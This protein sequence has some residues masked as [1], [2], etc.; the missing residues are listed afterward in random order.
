[1]K[2]TEFR[3]FSTIVGQT[4]VN[5]VLSDIKTGRHKVPV[6]FLRDCLANGNKPEFDRRKRE[7]EGVTFAGMF[8]GGRKLENLIEYSGFNILDIDKLDPVTLRNVFVQASRVQFTYACFRSPSNLGIKILVRTDNLAS[9]HTQAF[10][11][12][13]SYYEQL[14]DITI[15]P[16]GKDITRLCFYSYDP[17]TY[18]NVNSQIFKTVIMKKNKEIEQ[19]VKQIETQKIDITSGYNAWLNVGFALVDALG[20]NAR[21]YYH[22]VSAFNPEYSAEVC[23]KQFD[24]C[25]KSKRQGITASTFFY[26]AK[27]HGIDISKIK[28]FDVSTDNCPKPENPNIGK[29]KTKK[30]Y[31]VFDEAAVFLKSKIVTRFNLVTGLIEYTDSEHPAFEPLTDYVENNLVIELNKNQIMI[32]KD[33]LRCLLYSDFSSRFDPFVSYFENLPEW[34]NETDYITLLADTV[35]ID[36]FL[37]WQNAF[38]KWI[39]AVVA[40]AIDRNA[41]NHTAIVFTGPQGVGKTTW[42]LKLCPPALN[43]YVFSGTINPNNKD[44]LIHISECILINLDELENLNRSEIGSLKEIITKST[45]RFRRAYGHYSEKLVRRA[46][47]MGSVNTSQFLTDVTGSRRFLC[48]E[49]N[50]IEFNHNIDIDLVYAQAYA[51]YKSGFQYYFTKEEAAEISRRNER[52]RLMPPEEELLLV[53][54]KPVDASEA[55]L[56]LSASQIHS[57]LACKTVL[58]GNNSSVINLGKALRKHGFTR[59]KKNGVYVWALYE[60]SSIEVDNRFGNDSYRSPY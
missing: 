37:V 21:E 3:N 59:L 20:E 22:R 15:D 26:L 42:M 49:T 23:N 18:V 41:V 24:N 17:D 34:D 48:F 60:Y 30:T 39:V 2:I 25:L 28:S 35:Q 55:N 29:P 12:I 40:C 5:Q 56:F 9:N 16:S 19:V 36:D 45:I 27:E 54:F 47:F 31:N 13:K 33:K 53:Y 58:P 38:R 11:E 7:L 52:Y 57:K 46:S 44:T 8:E 1:M 51:L 14:L 4:S 43:E 10:D 32:N 50:D 6:Q